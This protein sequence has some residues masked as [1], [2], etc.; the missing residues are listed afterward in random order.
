M[1]LIDHT[2]LLGMESSKF[3]A[4]C[5]FIIDLITLALKVPHSVT[6]FFRPNLTERL[7]APFY[8]PIT[9]HRSPKGA[10]AS[11]EVLVI[12]KTDS[13]SYS[14]ICSFGYTLPCPTFPDF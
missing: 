4:F 9:L 2:D 11:T 3:Y 12:S 7:S 14:N 5:N 1:P 8:P 13:N 6:L 10:L